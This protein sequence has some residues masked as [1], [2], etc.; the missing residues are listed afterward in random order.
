MKYLIVACQ[1]CYVGILVPGPDKVLGRGRGVRYSATVCRHKLRRIKCAW[2]II[3][4]I[5]F[6]SHQSTLPNKLNCRLI[7]IRSGCFFCHIPSPSHICVPIVKVVR[8]KLCHCSWPTPLLASPLPLN[9][10]LALY[11]LIFFYNT[12]LLGNIYIGVDE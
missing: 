11:V 5:K 9:K 2:K 6:V 1:F 4:V 10:A 7:A 8:Q 3:L 12:N